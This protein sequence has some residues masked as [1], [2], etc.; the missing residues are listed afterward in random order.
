MTKEMVTDAETVRKVSPEEIEQL[1]QAL[2]NLVNEDSSLF[3]PADI[4]RLQ[5]DT[6]FFKR[7]VLAGK[8]DMGRAIEIARKALEWRKS[9]GI[10]DFDE[11][12]PQGAASTRHLC[13]NSYFPYGK[14]RSGAHIREY[15]GHVTLLLS[16]EWLFR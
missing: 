8:G 16:S 1:R 15:Y 11:H 3:H 13:V 12:S 5:E 4:R 14:T 9:F 6:S 2:E 7:F 10:N